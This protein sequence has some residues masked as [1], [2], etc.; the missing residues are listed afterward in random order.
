MYADY[1][2]AMKKYKREY[3]NMFNPSV[4]EPTT[5]YAQPKKNKTSC[6][7]KPF[8]FLRI[9]VRRTDIRHT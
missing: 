6:T 5:V 9:K 8:T 2:K 7:I 4:V 1:D 3:P